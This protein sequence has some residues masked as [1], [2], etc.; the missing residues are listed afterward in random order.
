MTERN[1]IIIA[2]ADKGGAVAIIEVEDNVKK[3]EQQL[4]NEGVYKK[5]QHDPTQTSK[6]LVN[7]TITRFKNNKLITET[8]HIDLK[9]SKRNRQN[10][11]PDQKYIKQET[12]NA[13]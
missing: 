5:L 10:F 13:Q 1:D 9:Y 6:R 8:S 4:N 2:K 3:A 11:T 7:D 12:L